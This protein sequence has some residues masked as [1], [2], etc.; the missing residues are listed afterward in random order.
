[1]SKLSR[2]GLLI[3]NTLFTDQNLP[4]GSIYLDS[5]IING[6]TT[7]PNYDPSKT[8]IVFQNN[9]VVQTQINDENFPLTGEYVIVVTSG[10]VQNYGA[11]N[12]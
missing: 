2:E 9:K 5:F 3:G 4:S 8:Y 10:N 6:P 7:T 11:R 1:M 12:I